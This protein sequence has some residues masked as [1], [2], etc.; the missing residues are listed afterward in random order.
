P[1]TPV[2]REKPVSVSNR[3]R[4]GV[5]II[6]S[7]IG[8]GL[9]LVGGIVTGFIVLLIGNSSIAPGLGL[10]LIALF[11]WPLM[12]FP[13]AGL[14]TGLLTATQRSAERGAVVGAVIFGGS[15]L[16][17]SISSIIEL[18]MVVA[19]VLV[20]AAVTGALIGWMSAALSPGFSAR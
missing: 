7:L 6:A 13:I 5:F 18:W 10:E 4:A 8:L 2:T 1:S 3:R 17:L 20:V 16:V 15:Q 19:P 12:T 11:L 14:C 9:G